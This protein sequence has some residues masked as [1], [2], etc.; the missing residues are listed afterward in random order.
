VQKTA[1]VEKQICQ[2]SRIEELF[3]RS[4]VRNSKEFIMPMPMELEL[5]E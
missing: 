2:N 1:L 3:E 4:P 5:E